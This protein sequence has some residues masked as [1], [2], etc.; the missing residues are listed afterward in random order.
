MELLT[1]KQ[2]NLDIGGSQKIK[3]GSFSVKSGDVILLTGPNGCGKSTIIKILMGAAFEYKGLDYSN[4]C[5]FYN[6]IIDILN[7]EHNNEI[8]RRSVC[9]VSQEDEFESDSVLDCFVNSIDYFVKDNKERYTFQFIKKFSIQ[10]CFRLDAENT[11]LDRRCHRIIKSI[12]L[13][14]NEMTDED[15][16]V[17]QYLAM[18]TKRMS[19]GQR[20]L[21]N[22]FSNLIRYD[23]CDLLILDEPLNN[24]DYNNVRAFSNVLTRIYN[25]K[26]ELAIL[27][28]THCRSIPI[29]NR[30]IEIDPLQKSIK[31][32]E[33]YIC[34]SCFG[35]ID[36]NGIYK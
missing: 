3:N 36:E 27:L 32:G 5:V 7:S 35:K 9:Y 18:N 16:M 15:I 30:I 11:K 8:F 17:V 19:G 31:E 29:V 13:D 22:I 12:G 24:L 6:G 2:L 21:T 28:V 26:P 34:S 4:S 1:I 25:T 23:F 10:K 20:K 33:A 14:K